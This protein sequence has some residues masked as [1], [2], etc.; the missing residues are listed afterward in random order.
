MATEPIGF[1]SQLVDG[2][3]GPIFPTLTR[4]ERW[5]RENRGAVVPTRAVLPILADVPDVPPRPV[6]VLANGERVRWNANRG[7]YVVVVAGV[8][9]DVATVVE[10]VR[11][12]AVADTELDALQTLPAATATWAAAGGRD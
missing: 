10:L 1:A 11:G 5:V 8:A 9:T 12:Y 4:A 3:W 7:V 2:S 6:V